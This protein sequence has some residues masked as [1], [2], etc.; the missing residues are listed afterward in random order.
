[1]K[2]WKELRRIRKGGTRMEET[3]KGRN[4]SLL[5]GD[6]ARK[7]WAEYFKNLLNVVEEREAEIVAVAGVQVPVM[8]VKS[9]KT[10]LKGH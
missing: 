10:G 8:G 4:G 1:M 2:F 5:K 3:M 9:Q 7:R 6:N